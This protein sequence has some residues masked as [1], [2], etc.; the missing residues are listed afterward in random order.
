[1]VDIKRHPFF[2]GLDWNKLQNKEIPPPIHLSMDE[3]DE[4]EELQYLKQVEK[5]KFKDQD[6]T[7]KN[8]TFNRVRQFTFLGGPQPK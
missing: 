8:A 2:R 5:V 1:M 4:N 6:Y 3:T 7:E